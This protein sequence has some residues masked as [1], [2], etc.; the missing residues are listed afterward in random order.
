M[1]VWRRY[2]ES[3]QQTLRLLPVFALGVTASCV[4]VSARSKRLTDALLKTQEIR[5]KTARH[6]T[7]PAV[8]WRISCIFGA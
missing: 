1:Q 8:M 7:F 6:A 5:H 2:R 4:A 3:N